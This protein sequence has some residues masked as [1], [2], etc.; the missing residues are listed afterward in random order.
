MSSNW[1]ESNNALQLFRVKLYGQKIRCS[2]TNHLWLICATEARMGNCGEGVGSRPTLPSRVLAYLR[3]P[4]ERGNT[5]G[6]QGTKD[7]FLGTIMLYH[8]AN[9]DPTEKL[10]SKGVPI[11]RLRRE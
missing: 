1:L 3:Y 10:T 11:S 6:S 5:P 8:M 2:K 9:H 7:N 4:Y